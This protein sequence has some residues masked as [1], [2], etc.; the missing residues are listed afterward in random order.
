[1]ECTLVLLHCTGEVDWLLHDLAA[2]VGTASEEHE[3]GHKQTVW[4]ENG[5][6]V[7]DYM[8]TDERFSADSLKDGMEEQGI[9]ANKNDLMALLDNI[10]S[11]SKQWRSSLGKHGE[12]LFYID[13]C[14]TRRTVTDEKIMALNRFQAEFP[15]HHKPPRHT[16]NFPRAWT[17]LA[18]NHAIGG[19]ACYWRNP[20][21]QTGDWRDKVEEFCNYGLVAGCSN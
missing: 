17:A 10:R 7:L 15:G 16:T 14:R 19:T 4:L 9:A 18:A 5:R 6:K 8:E 13:A 2:R 3:Y 1:M 11:L 12:L 21:K 20:S